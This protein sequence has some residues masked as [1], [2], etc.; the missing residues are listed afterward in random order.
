M[1][2]QQLSKTF[3][4]A[5]RVRSISLP[6]MSSRSIF[7]GPPVPWPGNFV[8]PFA[9]ADQMMHQMQQEM[10]RWFGGPQHHRGANG[11]P[12]I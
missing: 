12:S 4:R 5:T 11:V 7:R 2:R 9:M 8:N 1:L 6:V 3:P 10:D